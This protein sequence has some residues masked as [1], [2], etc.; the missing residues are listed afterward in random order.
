[1]ENPSGL[2]LIRGATDI[3]LIATNRSREQG[4]HSNFLEE[5]RL[6]VLL[7]ACDAGFEYVDVEATTPDVFSFVK[8]AKTRGSEVIISYHDFKGTPNRDQLEAIMTCELTNGADVCK[9]IGTA[10]EP[11]DCLTYLNFLNENR[12]VRLTCFGMGN[13]GIMSR[14]FSPVFG[15]EFTYA[16]S[17]AGEE[18]APGQLTI[19]DMRE[20]YR[21]LGV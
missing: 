3:P 15:G 7:A 9:I 19:R 18:S 10:R 16:S 14:I 4:G 13:P 5:E 2:K 20:I 21:I 12:G 1:M 11:S 6:G 8:E 17:D